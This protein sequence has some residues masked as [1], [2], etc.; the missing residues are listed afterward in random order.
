MRELLIISGSTQAAKFNLLCTQLSQSTL[1]EALHHHRTHGWTGYNVVKFMCHAM[2][3]PPPKTASGFLR[4]M[5]H[6]SP[7]LRGLARGMHNHIAQNRHGKLLVTEDVPLLAWWW[8]LFMNMS[9]LQT[10]T[11]HSGLSSSDRDSLVKKF[12]TVNHSELTA[13]VLPYKVGALGINLQNDCFSVYI[14][15]GSEQQSTEIQ[16]MMR[17]VRVQSLKSPFDQYRLLTLAA[18]E[19]SKRG[20]DC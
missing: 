20:D 14:M 9:L 2:R 13:L 19:L 5:A 18:D 15:T 1:S 7:L 11:Y 6:G 16:A 17:P 8:D 3:Q 12:N 4:Y 10:A